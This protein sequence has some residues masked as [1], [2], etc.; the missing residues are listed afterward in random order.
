M[1]IKQEKEQVM[2]GA[3]LTNDFWANY[4]LWQLFQKLKIK[5]SLLQFYRNEEIINIDN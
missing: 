5:W 3:T 4:I 1:D 2:A